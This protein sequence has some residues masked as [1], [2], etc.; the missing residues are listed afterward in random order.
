MTGRVGDALGIPPNSAHLPT[1]RKVRELTGKIREFINGWNPARN[2]SPGPRTPNKSS[3]KQTAEE[4]QYGP[5]V[6]RA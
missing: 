5:L 4:L 2:P 1:F 6:C 3:P